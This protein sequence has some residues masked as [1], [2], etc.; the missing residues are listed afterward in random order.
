MSQSAVGGFAAGLLGGL[1]AGDERRRN[2]RIDDILRRKTLEMD[3]TRASTEDEYA[4]FGGDTDQLGDLPEREEP[5]LKRSLNWLIDKGKSAFGGSGGQDPALQQEGALVD[6]TQQAI[7]V[8]QAVPGDF[9]ADGGQA[10]RKPTKNRKII[11]GRNL[12]D[13]ANTGAKTPFPHSNKERLKMSQ[14]GVKRLIE[15]TIEENRGYAD[16]GAVDLTEEERMRRAYGDDLYV[17]EEEA[18][19]NREKR[20]SGDNYRIGPVKRTKAGPQ[21]IPTNVS[22]G[23]IGRDVLQRT[24]ETFP[25]TIEAAHTARYISDLAA[26]DFKQAKGARAKGAALR[27]AATASV[28][29]AM[30][31]TAGFVKDVA[32]TPLVEG[33]LG[34]L[35]FEGEEKSRATREATQPPTPEGGSTGDAATDAAT[36]AIPTE[37]PTE[38]TAKEA[39]SAGAQMVPGH[40]DNPGQ[41]W[42]WEEIASSGAKPQDIPHV[43]IKDWDEF[44]KNYVLAKIRGGMDGVEANA[45]V[46]EMQHNGFMSNLQQAHYLMMAGK[47]EAAALAGRAA[48]QY[49]PN[50]VDVEFGWA[51]SKVDGS[52]VLFAMG[53]DDETGEPVGEPRPITTEFMGAMVENFKD[54]SAFRTWKKDMDDQY[55]KER[56]WFEV[57]R[58]DKQ[59]QID[60][61]A[62]QADYYRSGAQKNRAA[63]AA[64][65]A[66]PL[67]QSDYDRAYKE[68]L[69][70]NELMKIDDEA[71]ADYLADVMSQIYVR[72]APGTPYPTVINRVMSAYRD[73]TLEEKLAQLGIK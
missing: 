8:H 42:D 6:E 36:E 29:G 10:K 16:G 38:A 50:G 27:D 62:A 34:F 69:A 68:F 41:Q 54:P 37:K 49:F 61:R 48:Y 70:S 3:E 66:D 45:K 35:G 33:I 39:I 67:K 30:E 31:T 23:D 53:R 17:T 13:M 58:P 19:A 64:G 14:E 46:D 28:S 26:E 22:A 2:R 52:P 32:S 18:A 47:P 21:A 71:A 55:F 40:P 9:F 20:R 15:G 24:A 63:A 25:E 65:G 4:A 72:M 11:Q 1:K 59:S 51:K 7:P 60:L 44:R 56:E 73:G 43:G 12:I 5:F 57:T